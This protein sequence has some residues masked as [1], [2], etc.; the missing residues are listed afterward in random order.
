MTRVRH[1]ENNRLL[2]QPAINLS[3]GMKRRDFVDFEPS[4]VETHPYR[5]VVHRRLGPS[6]SVDRGARLTSKCDCGRVWIGLAG[7]GA[8]RRNASE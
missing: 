2:F 8:P 3:R 7:G 5:C 1:L 4:K 6:G